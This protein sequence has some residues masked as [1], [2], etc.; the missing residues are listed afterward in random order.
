MLLLGAYLTY[1]QPRVTRQRQLTDRH[2]KAVDRLGSQHLDVRVG[3]IHAPERIA[4]DPPQD[5][6]TT[7]EVLTAFVR[8]HAPGQLPHRT[9]RHPTANHHC[10]T[11]TAGNSVPS[12]ADESTR[13]PTSLT[14]KPGGGP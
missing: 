13:W 7:E 5:R 14:Q 6:A 9:D 8:G 10:H 2:T 3:G 11:T 4:R 12:R 1:R